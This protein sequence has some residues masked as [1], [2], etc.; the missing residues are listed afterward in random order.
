MLQAPSDGSVWETPLDFSKFK[1]YRVIRGWRS[2]RRSAGEANA[3][4]QSPMG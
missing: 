3:R 4:V 2:A 1:H